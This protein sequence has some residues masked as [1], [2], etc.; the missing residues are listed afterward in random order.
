MSEYDYVIGMM[1]NNL[2]YLK[3][4]LEIAGL[5]SKRWREETYMKITQLES[6]I[7]RLKGES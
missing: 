1:E 5:M 4:S 3:N 6:A 2:F 7:K